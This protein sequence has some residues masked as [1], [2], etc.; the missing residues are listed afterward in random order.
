MSPTV[1]LVHGAFADASGWS[2]VISRLTAAGYQTYAPA[3]PLRSLS[4][5]AAYIRAFLATIEGPVVLVG[6]SYGGAVITNAAVGADNV[7]ALVYI[8]GFALEEGEAAGAATALGSDGPPPDL[9]QVI[10]LRP[11]P[12][13]GDGNAD[14][15]LKPEIFPQ[16]FCQDLPPEEGAI[17]ALS[18]RPAALATLGEPSGPPAWKS[19]PAWYLVASS[20]RVIPP[21]A[22]RAMALRAGATTVE[23]ESSHVAMISHPD[24]VT[25]LIQQAIDAAG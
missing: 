15:Y 17:M 16:V 11:F 1:V 18:Q 3:N 7:T 14:G 20:D 6:H 9:T 2:G 23:I 5:D 8:A 24:E 4:G 25:A 10:L 12:D 13:A 22:E 19:L 21:A